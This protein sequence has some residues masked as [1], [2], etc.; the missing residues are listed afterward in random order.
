MKCLV[1]F[2]TRP[3]AIKMA[4]LV[5]R[6]RAGPDFECKVCCTAQ[7]REM[8]D[9]VLEI[10]G[11]A[12]DYD[13]DL[14]QADQSL[15]GL[16][17]RV[18]AAMEGVLEDCRPDAV[19]VQGDTTTTMAAALS[20]FYRKIPVHHVEAGLRT[21]NRYSPFPE[22]INRQ[23]ASRLASVHYAPTERARDNLLGEGV[24]PGSIVVTGN[25]VIDA[26][27]EVVRRIEGSER[28]SGR[29]RAGIQERGFPI[30]ERRYL[31]VTG[32]RRENFGEG[33]RRVCQALAR[34]ASEHPEIDLVYPVHLNP[35]VLEPVKAQLS[36]TANIHLIPPLD[37]L[38]FVYLMMHSHAIITDSGGIQEEAP[39]LGKPVLVTRDATE[40]PEGIEAG[41][42][43]LTGADAESI[44]KAASRLLSD[45]R[46]YRSLAEARNPFGDGDAAVRIEAFL[47]AQAAGAA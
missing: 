10:F 21:R 14:M 31:L 7:H 8:L 22:E 4:V 27:L 32:H 40:R 13:L 20:A 19:F 3:E 37:Y 39:S 16:T 46:F 30:S 33:L 28:L 2:G 45:E 29:L 41:S 34:I 35:N 15:A 1:V 18:L 44:V 5:G 9:Q 24:D 36:E 25:T 23:I 47:A 12:P 43:V 17:A 42:V 6:L 26:L 11:I 38:S